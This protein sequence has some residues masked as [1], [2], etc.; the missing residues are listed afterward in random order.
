MNHLINQSVS[1]WKEKWQS[2]NAREQRLLTWGSVVLAVIF[3][4]GLILAPLLKEKKRSENRLRA[5]KALYQKTQKQVQQINDL[6]LAKKP[7]LSSNMEVLINE[8]STKYGLTL[9]NMQQLQ[10]N[11]Q[12]IWQLTIKPIGQG[13]V[14]NVIAWLDE[15]QR[16]GVNVI[17]FTINRDEAEDMVRVE[18]IQLQLLY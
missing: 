17:G 7:H 10:Q 16:A 4:Y 13:D 12:T 15:L 18:N 8:L 2:L 11:Q 5:E 14:A 9:N 1:Q 3:Y 6:G